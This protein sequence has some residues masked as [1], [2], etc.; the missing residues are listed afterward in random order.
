MASEIIDLPKL[1][2]DCELTEQSVYRSEAQ[3][4]LFLE[5][6]GERQPVSGLRWAMH[7]F[8]KG[9]ERG[10]R[11]YMV[12][13]AREWMLEAAQEQHPRPTVRDIE[14]RLEN[15]KWPK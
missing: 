11:R 13:Q 5:R 9:Y 15:V 2:D 14:Q 6:L 8:L 10:A 4:R 7:W 1:A 12:A 3:C